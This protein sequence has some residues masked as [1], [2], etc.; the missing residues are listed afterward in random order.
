[1]Q[2]EIPVLLTQHMQEH[3]ITVVV[4]SVHLGRPVI[5]QAAQHTQGDPSVLVTLTHRGWPTVARAA[6]DLQEVLTRSPRAVVHACRGCCL[7]LHQHAPPGAAHTRGI[8]C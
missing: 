2:P 5:A 6:Q 7:R 4:T 3:T 8:G 1:M